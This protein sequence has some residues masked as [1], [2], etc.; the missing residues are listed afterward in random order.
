MSKRKTTLQDQKDLSATATLD[1]TTELLLHTQAF[2]REK[3]QAKEVD[4][5]RTVRGRRGVEVKGKRGHSTTFSSKNRGVQDRIARDE[6][7]AAEEA[8]NLEKS[9]VAL[10]KKARLYEALHQGQS[11]EG[12]TEQASQALLV[13]FHGKHQEDMQHPCKIQPATFVLPGREEEEEEEGEEEEL[14][15]YEDEFGRTRMIPRNQVPS[16]EDEKE[17]EEDHT[18]ERE[19]YGPSNH[20]DSRKENR[21]M[22]VGFYQFA[23][24]EEKRR[25]QQRNLEILREETI[26]ARQSHITVEERRQQVLDRRRALLQERKR[27]RMEK[28]SSSNNNDSSSSNVPNEAIDHLLESL[29]PSIAT[30]P[31]MKDQNDAGERK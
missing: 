13:D 11:V 20:Y 5:A 1:F 25:Q 6:A 10:E 26:R 22:G 3:S 4:G 16:S 12:W 23:Q 18:Y 31:I 17:D 21:A 19:F 24:N 7:T 28:D 14:V 29:R 2:A 9:Q 27:R 8:K 15:E 30:P